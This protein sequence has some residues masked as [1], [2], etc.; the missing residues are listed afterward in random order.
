MFLLKLRI[1]LILALFLE[2]CEDEK[3][4]EEN[5]SFGYPKTCQECWQTEVK[6]VSHLKSWSYD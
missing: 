3:R 5:P 6:K 1:S 4:S 2:G